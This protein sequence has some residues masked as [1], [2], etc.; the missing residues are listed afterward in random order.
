MQLISTSLRYM[1][2]HKGYMICKK[3]HTHTRLQTSDRLPSL[4][5]EEVFLSLQQDNKRKCVSVSGKQDGKSAVESGRSIVSVQDP[6]QIGTKFI[7]VSRSLLSLNELFAFALLRR[8]NKNMA[9]SLRQVACIDTMGL[10]GVGTPQ[11]P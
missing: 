6:W 4:N 7:L 11:K 3:K 5:I 9:A 1:M 10:A 2:Q 8:K